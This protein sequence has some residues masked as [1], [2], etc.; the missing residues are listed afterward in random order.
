MQ[1]RITRR[2]ALLATAFS[3][4]AAKRADAQSTQLTAL[5]IGSAPNDDITPALYAL[6]NDL[7]RSAGLDVQLSGLT[8]GS[9]ISA[10]VAGGALDIGRSSMLPLI[11][12]RSHG[13][14]FDLLAP[15]G[16]YSTEAPVAALVVPIASPLKTARDLAG[17]VVSVP[18]LGDLDTIGVRTWIDANGGDSK[19]TQY[20]EMPGSSVMNELLAG[21]VAAGTLQNPYL[22]QAIKSGAARVL[23][24]HIS[25]I[26][27]RLLQSSWFAMDGYVEK[28]VTVC[29]AFAQ[30]M[31]TASAYCNTHR[32]E[33][34]AILA[35]YTK[36]DPAVVATMTRTTFASSIDVG[37][38]QP[39]IN[40][41]AKYRVIAQAF[42]AS[43]FIPRRP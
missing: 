7:F 32:P 26:G 9:A 5:R 11:T 17:K 35:A 43:D 20:V 1:A 8:S 19:D 34:A 27:N 38:I 12:A 39:L 6:R 36:I 30:V 22:S 13:I 25:A 3:V 41:A 14:A 21:R 24:Y 18:A 23:A 31:Q 4:V 2:N 40:A 15:S 16:L 33:T 42:P 28:N 29:R 37:Q 10:A